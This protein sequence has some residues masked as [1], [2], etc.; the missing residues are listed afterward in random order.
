MKPRTQKLI[1]RAL[2][3][4][5]LQ[6]RRGPLPGQALTRSYAGA[7][8]TNLT[9]DWSPAQTT[10]NAELRWNLRKLRN[11]S[12][13]LARNKGVM[14]KFLSMLAMNVVGAQGIAL[15]VVFDPHGNSTEKRDLELAAEIESAWSEWCRP[16]TCTASGRLSWVGALSHAIRTIGRDG[17]FLCREIKNPPGN[18]FGYALHFRDVAWLDEGWNA[19]AS[20]SGNRIL[21]SVEIDNYDRPVRYWLTRPSSDYLYSELDPRLGARTP[22]DA[23]EIIH[24]F[25]ITEDELQTRGVPMVHAAMENIHIAGGHVDAELYASRAGACITDWLKP[26]ADSPP[27]SP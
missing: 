17:E 13:E 16:E 12:R 7:R 25:L 18:R 26:P 9:A 8:L 19:I 4:F 23:S 27:S 6:R 14:V 11:R 2:A 10:A 3:R 21:M 20:G 22:V 5:G 24:K 1:D 15:R